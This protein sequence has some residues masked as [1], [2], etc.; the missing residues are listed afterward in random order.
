MLAFAY[1]ECGLS[2]DEFFNLSWY[3]WSLEVHKVKQKRI[4]E[5]RIWEGHAILTRQL[6]ASIL[7]SA[8]KSYKR[9]F[10]PRELIPLSFDKKEIKESPP[11]TEKSMKQRLG[12]K[13]K[14][15]GS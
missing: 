14:K 9:E 2:V 7:N 10:D 15:N 12:T 4:L 11:L 13:F 1:A 6:M 5:N 8:G 3:Q